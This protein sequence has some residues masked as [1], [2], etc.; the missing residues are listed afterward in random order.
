MEVIC[1]YC[2]KPAELVDSI[3][4]YKN[5]S[6]GMVWWCRPCGAYV[7]THKTSKK[8]KPLGRL[9][10]KELRV[11]KQNAHAV[12]DPIWQKKVEFEGAPTTKTRQDAYAW[13]A[14]QLGISY[15]DCH[16]GM[17]D[18]DMCKKV[19]YVCENRK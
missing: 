3:E 9:A 4:I 8:H 19:I 17:F 12:F 14:Q 2:D 18:V 5:V 13:L 7:G 16:I 15:H 1:D 11:W 10:N 6:Y